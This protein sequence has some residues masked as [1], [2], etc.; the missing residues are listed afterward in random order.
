MKLLY[1]IIFL[2]GFSFAFA[3]SPDCST[4]SAMCSGQGGP[5]NNTHPGHQEEIKQVMDLF[6]RVEVVV[7]MGIMVL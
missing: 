4:A 6:Q 3:Q 7:A 5:Y 1:K 2:L